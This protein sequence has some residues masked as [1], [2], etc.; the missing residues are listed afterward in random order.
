M[1]TTCAVACLEEAARQ[2]VAFPDGLD[3]AVLFYATGE[4]MRREFARTRISAYVPDGDRFDVYKNGWQQFRVAL[5]TDWL[6]ACRTSREGRRS[7]G[8]SPQSSG[9]RPA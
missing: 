5:E 4:I 7:T 3:H 1:R 2:H 8:R 6:P 9:T